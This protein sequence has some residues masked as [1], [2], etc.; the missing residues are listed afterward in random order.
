MYYLKNHPSFHPNLNHLHYNLIK[1]LT[2]ANR[3]NEIKY[4]MSIV[5]PQLQGDEDSDS[6]RGEPGCLSLTF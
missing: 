1:R 2:K 6:Y 5:V 3:K 4:H